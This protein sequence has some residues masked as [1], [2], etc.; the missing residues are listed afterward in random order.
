MAIQGKRHLLP[1]PVSGTV[2]TANVYYA[3]TTLQTPSKHSGGASMLTLH[4]S[5][6]LPL[7]CYCSIS[8]RQKLRHREA[9]SP[10]WHHTAT[11]SLISHPFALLLLC[12]RRVLHQEF[13]TKGGTNFTAF[14]PD[15][16]H[17]VGM[18]SVGR[19]VRLAAQG[20]SGMAPLWGFLVFQ[21]GSG[22]EADITLCVQDT[23]PYKDVTPH[24]S[25]APSA[26]ERNP[27]MKCPWQ[28]I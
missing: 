24:L 18:T 13:S 2:M 8:Q 14:S 7:R 4:H 23:C 21:K 5:P 12:S 15:F 28:G 10:A 9:K 3:F 17:N 22:R 1:I 16:M 19:L 27:R 11:R 25:G 6:T 20:Q 26:P